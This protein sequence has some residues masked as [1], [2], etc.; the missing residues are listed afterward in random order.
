MAR[1]GHFMQHM[2]NMGVVG[3]RLFAFQISKT[4]FARDPNI[5]L[6]RCEIF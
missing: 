2:W 3:V 1:D 6:T 4:R 5:F